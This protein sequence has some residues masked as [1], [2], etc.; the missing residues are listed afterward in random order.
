MHDRVKLTRAD[1]S[2][3]WIVYVVFIYLALQCKAYAEQPFKVVAYQ[4]YNTMAKFDP[5]VYG[6]IE[7]LIYKLIRVKADGELDLLSS[8]LTDLTA[9]KSSRDSKNSYNKVKLLVG[10][11]GAKKNSAHFSVM[12][13]NSTTRN[14]FVKNIAKFC[15]KYQLDGA[16][17]DWEYPENHQDQANALLLFK[18][19]QHEFNQKNLMLTAAITYTP[20]QVKFAKQVEPFVNQINLMVYEP[21]KG[22]TTFQQQI[23]FAV[24][25]IEKEDL[26][27]E[28]LVMGLPFYGKNIATG[29]TMTYSNIVQAK[30]SGLLDIS[31]INYMNLDA[32]KNNVLMMKAKGYSGV[33]FWELGFDTELTSKTSLLRGINAPGN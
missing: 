5:K 23:D 31:N 15:Q 9:L 14:N 19:L 29:K 4:K 26:S 10:I 28:K 12:A 25:L 17:I 32:I 2:F 24:E 11:G 27:D 16:D 30:K 18:A 20:E 21:I 3:R 13:A 6:Y 1:K 8:T 33:M 7:Q 22:L